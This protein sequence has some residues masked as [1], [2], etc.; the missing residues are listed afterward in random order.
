MN[1]WIYGYMNIWIDST[2]RIHDS[3]SPTATPLLRLITK[4]IPQ[5]GHRLGSSIIKCFVGLALFERKQARADDDDDLRVLLPKC[6][7]K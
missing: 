5:K 4:R 3:S 7:F 1:T 2:P 6:D